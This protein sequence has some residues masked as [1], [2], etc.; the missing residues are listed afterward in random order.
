MHRWY[1]T[2][3]AC[4][5]RDGMD[6]I[7]PKLKAADT[8]VLA[9][10]VHIPLTERMQTFIDRLCPLIEP[11]LEFRAGRTRGRLRT[12]DALRRFVLVVTGGWW[13]RG[14][15][16]TVVR[17]IAELAADSGV[18]LAGARVRAYAFLI[19]SEDGPTADGQ[20]LLEVAKRAGRESA[21]AGR[22]RPETLAE[23]SRPIIAAQDLQRLYDA[24]V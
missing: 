12:D 16:D 5:I 11:W 19:R 1:T 15:C 22:M 17:I 21:D 2:P 20:A 8:F 3:G 24:W 13:E 10:P 14:N 9:T 4:C 18:D 23:A 6:G 7:V